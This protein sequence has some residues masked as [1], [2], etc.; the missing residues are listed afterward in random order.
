M[1]STENATQDNNIKTPHTSHPLPFYAASL[2]LCTKLL[3]NTPNSK[4]FGR[5]I[6]P[7]WW[8]KPFLNCYEVFGTNVA[9]YFMILPFKF[10]KCAV[11]VFHGFLLTLCTTNNPPIRVLIMPY[12]SKISLIGY[13]K[14]CLASIGIPRIPKHPRI[15]PRIVCCFDLCA[16]HLRCIRYGIVVILKPW[17]KFFRC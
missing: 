11:V 1:F 7:P 16:H 2:P 10:F 4:K 13:R 3:Q 5:K 17:A 12:L 6:A 8:S 9:R 14:E 15:K